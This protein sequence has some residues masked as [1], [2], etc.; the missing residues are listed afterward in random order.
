MLAT[1]SV[2]LMVAGGLVPLQ[3]LSIITAF[4]LIFILGIAA[5][6]FRKWLI[7][8]RPQE[9]VAEA[10]PARLKRRVGHGL[11]SQQGHGTE[12]REACG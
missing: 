2:A 3:T 12:P 1:V 7:E 6:S 11:Q 4:P 8:Y 5:L 9:E 10:R